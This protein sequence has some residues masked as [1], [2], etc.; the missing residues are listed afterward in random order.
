MITTRLA[1]SLSITLSA[2]AVAACSSAKTQFYTLDSVA[3]AGAA[4]AAH[5]AVLVGPVSI[6][7][8]VDR[9]QFVLQVASNRIEIDELNCW[10]A[11]LDDAVARAVAG[12]LSVLLATHDVAVVPLANFNATHRV[13]LSVQRFE[14]IPG[15]AVSVDALWTVTPTARSGVAL[16]GRTVAQETVTAPGYDALAAAHSRV[17]AKMSGD[18]AAAIE[19]SGK[20]KH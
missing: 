2:F 16:S 15:R 5:Y 10:A 9:P 1:Y 20:K 14:S 7:P 11:P 12:N 18:I 19:D 4:P 3:T 6:P 8:S 13:T 17:L